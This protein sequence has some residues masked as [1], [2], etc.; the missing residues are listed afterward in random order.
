MNLSNLI[1]SPFATYPLSHRSEPTNNDS[2]GNEQYSTIAGEFRRSD[3]VLK[4][5]EAIQQTVNR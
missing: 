3:S 1:Q 2:F 5:N 4:M